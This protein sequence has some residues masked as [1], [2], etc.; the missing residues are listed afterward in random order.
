M[1]IKRQWEKK[2]EKKKKE[3]KEKK[4]IILNNYITALIMSRINLRSLTGCISSFRKSC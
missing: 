4:G 1:E 3:K 2:K